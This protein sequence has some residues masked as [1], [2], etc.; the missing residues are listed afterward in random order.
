MGISDEA[1]TIVGLMITTEDFVYAWVPNN[2]W[3]DWY[4]TSPARSMSYGLTFYAK[5]GSS[6]CSAR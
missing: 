2:P 3:C 4:R 5:Y 1:A 6:E